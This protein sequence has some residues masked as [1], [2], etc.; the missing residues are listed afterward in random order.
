MSEYNTPTHPTPPQAPPPQEPMQTSFC[1]TSHSLPTSTNLPP[2]SPCA[3]KKNPMTLLRLRAQSHQQ[4]PTHML[5]I[6]HQTRDKYSERICPHCLH[7]HIG[8]EIHIILH[9]LATKHIAK[10]LIES[11]TQFLDDTGQPDWASLNSHQQTSLIL[12]DPPT[13]LP[14]KFHHTWL[15]TMLP[16]I[17]TY[18]ALL[19]KHL[20]STKPPT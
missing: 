20:Y 2:I 11:L 4:V 14:K 16:P 15:Q 5:T 12:S 13:P 7:P 6:E 17:L 1:T 8:S 3:Q 18:I 9:C 10:D 19:E